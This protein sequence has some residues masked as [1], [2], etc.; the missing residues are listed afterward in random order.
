VLALVRT[1]FG[2]PTREAARA[3]V[4]QLLERLEHTVPKAAEMLREVEDDILAALC[5]K[6]GRDRYLI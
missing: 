1:I 6:M 4:A 3:A 5:V 2:Q